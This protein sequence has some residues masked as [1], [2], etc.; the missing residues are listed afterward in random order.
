MTDTKVDEVLT[1][2]PPAFGADEA[3]AIARA[4]FGISGVATSVA[5]ERDQTFLIDGPRP[6]VLKVSNAAE[7]AARLDME[8]LAAQ[9]VVLVDPELP[10]ALPWRVPGK[11]QGAADPADPA[12]YRAIAQGPGGTHHVRAYDR[13]PGHASVTGAGL[14]DEAIRDWGTMAARVGRALRGFWHPSASRVMLW[15][16]QHALRLRPLLGAVA[17]REARDLVSAALDRF[18]A[19]VTPVWPVLRGQVIHT[20]L[21]ASNVLVDDAGQVTGIIDFGDTS[22]TAL[23]VDPVAVV[24]TVVGGRTGDDVFRAARLALDGYDK[25]T[26]LEPAERRVFGELLAARM[27]AAVV[28]PASRGALYEDPEALQADLRI[29]AVT[30]LRLFASVGWDEVARR[31]GGGEP[32]RRRTVPAL[33][34]RRARA[35]GPALTGLSYREPLHMVRGDGVWLDDA[36]GRRYLDAYNNVPVVGHG[37]PRVVEAIVRQA[38]RLNTNIRYLHETALEVAERLVATTGSGLEVVMFVNSGSEANDLAWRIARA[39]TGN[40]GGL[41]TD[42]AY[43]GISDAIVALSPEDWGDRAAP[44]HVRTWEPPD[45]LRGTDRSVES[46]EAAIAGLS[47]AGHAPALAIH[48]GVLTSD[49]IV[50]LDPAVAG[51]LVRRTH[52]AGALWV[53]DEVQGGYGRTGA[54]MWSYQRLGIVPDIVTLGKP[55]GNG[56]PVAAVITRRDIAERFA[57]TTDF[58]ST[59]GGNPVAMAAALAV[60]EV[61]DDERLIG[62]AGES[63]GYLA[64]RL[65]QLQGRAAHIGAVRGIGLAIGVEIVQPGTTEPDAAATNAIVE[66]MRERGVLIGTTGRHANTLKIRP[67]LVFERR[68]ADQL[69]AALEDVLAPLGTT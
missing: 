46:F 43:H 19:V 20:D 45:A 42:F 21:C 62:R 52:D 44:D 27:C 54:A 35:F 22:Y 36:D 17:D 39:V 30:L 58:F 24:E 23:V 25:V 16:A 8:A 61:I 4:L 68:H 37:H 2:A 51:E 65:R 3:A 14:S 18:E 26:P 31:L 9:R 63:G 67:P 66:G 69:V 34:E 32:G 49:G 50:D 15:D 10:V 53:A 57:A 59:F 40:D 5:S 1:A 47:A 38:R 7:D 64:G 6:A 56:H 11:P 55:M 29:E 33:V 60:L 48:D 41:C 13:L 12:A 28:V